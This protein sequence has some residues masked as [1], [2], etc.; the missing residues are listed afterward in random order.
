MKK[1]FKITLLLAVAG[2]LSQCKKGEDDPFISFRTRK[3]RVVGEWT[4]TSGSSLDNYQP[5]SGNGNSTSTIYTETSFTE[6]YTSGPS[7]NTSTGLYSLKVEF[8]KDGTFNWTEIEGNNL[9][10]LSGLWNFTGRVGDYKNK[11]QVTLTILSVNDSGQITSYT[12]KEPMESF[13]L[14]ELRNK[15]MV[16]VD[17]S[18]NVNQNSNS[19]YKSEMVFERK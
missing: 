17:E 5:V 19:T 15:T 11:E 8:K 12:G 18:S 13:T 1:L 3:A 2:I 7:S 10:T 16:I 4:L 9:T 14:K 6:T